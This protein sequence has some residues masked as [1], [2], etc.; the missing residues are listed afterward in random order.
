M[1]KAPDHHEKHGH[2]E[3]AHKHDEKHDA[4][5]HE[6]PKHDE[7]APPQTDHVPAALDKDSPQGREA[8]E[9]LKT[10]EEVKHE[11]AAKREALPDL[12]EED[13][14]RIAQQTGRQNPTTS[15]IDLEKAESGGVA[16]PESPPV[17]EDSGKKR[18]KDPEPTILEQ[19]S[20]DA[21]AQAAGTPLGGGSPPSE[22]TDSLDQSF[23]F[24]L[25]PDPDVFLVPEPVKLTKG[26]IGGLQKEGLEAYLFG[27]RVRHDAAGRRWDFRREPVDDLWSLMIRVQIGPMLLAKGG[28]TL[29]RIPTADGEH[30]LLQVVEAMAEQASEHQRTALAEQKK[31]I[32]ERETTAKAD[33]KRQ[34]E[35]AE[36]EKRAQDKPD[37]VDHRAHR[38]AQEEAEAHA[39]AAQA[40]PAEKAWKDPPKDDGRRRS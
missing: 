16:V 5:K 18:Q 10:D 17:I 33:E 9:R 8:Q 27:E 21:A 20:A 32:H 2:D 36:A 7:K 28:I 12:A 37:E 4:H 35:M 3:K 19:I 11:E 29:D 24:G 23:E 31:L 30:Y 34:R 22:R 26:Q 14:G 40:A 13:R 25:T 6:A 15:E 1:A 39:E 38:I